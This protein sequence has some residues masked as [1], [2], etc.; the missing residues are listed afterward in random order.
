MGTSLPIS[1]E[2][3]IWSEQPW[4]LQYLWKF[5]RRVNQLVWANTSSLYMRFFPSFFLIQEKSSKFLSQL[6]SV[7][8]SRL[9]VQMFIFLQ[10]KACD[11]SHLY[12]ASET[13]VKHTHGLGEFLKHWSKIQERLLSF[14]HEFLN[15]PLTPFSHLFY[16]FRISYKSTIFT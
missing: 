14:F 7:T 6:C 8:N 16:I 5:H 4:S 11:I 9:D 2:F 3:L 1:F 15:L 10:E 12:F 13:K